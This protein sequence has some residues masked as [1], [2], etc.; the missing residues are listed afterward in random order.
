M[1]NS[2]ADHP[3][4]RDLAPAR[5]VA[6]HAPD[7]RGDGALGGRGA[8][9]FAGNGALRRRELY[10][11]PVSYHRWQPALPGK[12]EGQSALAALQ[13]RGALGADLLR[14]SSAFGSIFHFCGAFSMIRPPNQNAA[15]SPQSMSVD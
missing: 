7:R 1:L 15:I 10:L 8:V 13:Q 11:R 14:S 12:R 4:D 3:A 9:D 2:V 6:R 5:L